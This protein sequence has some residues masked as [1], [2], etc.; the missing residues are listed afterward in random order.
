M[1]NVLFKEARVKVQMINAIMKYSDQYN[2]REELKAKN[3]SVLKFM[4]YD[5]MRPFYRMHKLA[6]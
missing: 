6:L 3:F 2:S 1:S 5:V 4:Y